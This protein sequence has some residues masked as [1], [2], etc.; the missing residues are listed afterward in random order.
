[1]LT[2][3]RHS[4]IRAIHVSNVGHTRS[5]LLLIASWALGINCCDLLCLFALDAG[6]NNFLL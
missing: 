3:H 6:D 1:M 2:A 5:L 4:Q